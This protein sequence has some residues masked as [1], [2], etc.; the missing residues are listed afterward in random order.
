MPR[1][2]NEK[3][4]YD[5]FERLGGREE[6]LGTIGQGNGIFELSSSSTT[7]RATLPPVPE[8]D[9]SG[10]ALEV[11]PAAG[12]GELSGRNLNRLLALL[13]ALM[14]ACGVAAGVTVNLAPAYLDRITDGY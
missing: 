13:V 9:S 10:G 4:R 12:V 11:R 6:I 5:V 8:A 1:G 14:L 2:W 7:E 3:P